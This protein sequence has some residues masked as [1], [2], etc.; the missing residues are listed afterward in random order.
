MLTIRVEELGIEADDQPI[1]T[2]THRL[3]RRQV[4][5]PQQAISAVDTHNRCGATTNV[6]GDIRFNTL[7]DREGID[8]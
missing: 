6:A 2:G 3:H 8:G 4:P 5:K 7:S 1:A